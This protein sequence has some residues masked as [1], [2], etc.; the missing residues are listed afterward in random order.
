[1]KSMFLK[2]HLGLG[3]AIICNG[4]VRR[5][6]CN[7]DLIIVP[8]R[9]ANRESVKFMFRDLGNRIAIVDADSDD[10]IKAQAHLFERLGSTIRGIGAYHPEEPLDV[11]R[12]DQQ[13]YDQCQVPF[14]YRWAAFYVSR[15]LSDE[16]EP[17]PKKKLF[18]YD[19]VRDFKF[20]EEYIHHADEITVIYRLGHIFRWCS[21]IERANEIHSIDGG[22]FCLMNSLHTSA[23]K[24]V[25]H[26][27]ARTTPSP[28][29]AEGWTIID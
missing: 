27:Y 3:D 13:F 5:L 6:L 16:I 20:R 15:D 18:Y 10:E 8:C 22:P 24:K 28:T 11:T 29:I 25:W 7:V 12:W 9:R 26:R 2:W 1:M 4:L 14:E 23:S 21:V 19:A 17:E